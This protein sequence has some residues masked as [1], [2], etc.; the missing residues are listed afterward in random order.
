MVEKKLLKLRLTDRVFVLNYQA[1]GTVVK[2]LPD[3]SFVVNIPGRGDV[4]FTAYGT[5]GSGSD[6]RVFFENPIVIIPPS[7]T[8]LWEAYKR[9]TKVLYD[10]LVKLDAV[11]GIREGS[12]GAS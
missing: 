9:L 5:V 3:G 7:N 1:Y 11:G 12:N 10:E 8:R 6:V 2:V 4:H